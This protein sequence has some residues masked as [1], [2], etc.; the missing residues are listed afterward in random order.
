LIR[1]RLNFL[2]YHD[3]TDQKIK[4]EAGEEGAWCSSFVNWCVT[5]SGYLGTNS[6]WSLSW[7]HNGKHLDKPER[8]CIVVFWRDQPVH[9]TKGHVGFY[10]GEDPHDPDRL[11]LLGGNQSGEAVTNESHKKSRVLDYRWPVKA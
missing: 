1:S 8:G 10:M 2:R 3:S 11:M 7:R 4:E 9:P 5:T 6:A